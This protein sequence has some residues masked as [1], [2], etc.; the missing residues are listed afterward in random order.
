M[1]FS[2]VLF[3]LMITAVMGHHGPQHQVK[4]LSERIC[5]KPSSALLTLRASLYLKEGNVEAAKKDLAQA[6]KLNAEYKPAKKLASV[7]K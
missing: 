7:I 4:V 5:E 1:K 2:L 6:L 3:C